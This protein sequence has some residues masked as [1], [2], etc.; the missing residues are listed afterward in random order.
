MTDTDNTLK[1]VL[2]SDDQVNMSDSDVGWQKVNS[3]SNSSQTVYTDTGN[4]T[5]NTVTLLIE[6]DDPNQIV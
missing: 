6:H 1:V 2:D 5:S 3:E 4:I